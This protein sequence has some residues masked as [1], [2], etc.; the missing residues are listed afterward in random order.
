MRLIKEIKSKSGELHFRRWKIITIPWICSIYIHGIYKADE[1]LHLHNHSWK[2]WT[3]ILSGGY[4]EELQGGKV[5]IRKSGHM[6]KANLSD[7]HKIKEM[8][9]TP[10]Y[11]LAVVG[12]RAVEEW[13]YMTEN[14]FVDHITFRNN[15]RN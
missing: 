5:R 3:M 7:F 15:K 13:G 10:T 11:T 12:M 8:I 2:I 14:G 6:A 4:I 1:D 9:K